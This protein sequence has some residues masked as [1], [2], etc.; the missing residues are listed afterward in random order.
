MFVWVT[1]WEDKRKGC[2]GPW[3]TQS[4]EHPTLSHD[5]IVVRSSSALSGRLLE[6]V[7]LPLPLP[8]PPLK[9]KKKTLD[10]GEKAQGG[11]VVSFGT[12]ALNGTP[13]FPFGGD[14]P[15]P[16][17]RSFWSMTSLW[18]L[19]FYPRVPWLLQLFLSY[20]SS[21]SCIPDLCSW[22]HQ[23][24]GA[25]NLMGVLKAPLPHLPFLYEDYLLN[26]SQYSDHSLSLKHCFSSGLC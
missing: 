14:H 11:V 5:L 23:P 22:P 15:S 10:E 6:I 17:F 20:T 12:G 9:K 16:D 25:A 4:V 3:G 21:T 2:Q 24:P 8:L 19:N 1:A 26:I 18:P 7:S 13:S